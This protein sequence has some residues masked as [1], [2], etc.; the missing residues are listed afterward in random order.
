M[1]GA[2]PMPTRIRKRRWFV[3]VAFLGAAGIGIGIELVVGYALGRLHRGEGPPKP[4]PVNASEARRT[5][6]EPTSARR[7]RPRRAAAPPSTAKGTLTGEHIES[8][9]G[10]GFQV[11]LFADNDKTEA[12][13]AECLIQKTSGK[14]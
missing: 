3:V 8:V 10:A 5:Y 2:F 4:L 6:T 12:W 14:A 11:R 13:G 1:R 7:T 9:G